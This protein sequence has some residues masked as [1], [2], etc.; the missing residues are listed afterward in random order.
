MRISAVATVLVLAASAALAGPPV[1]TAI[2]PADLFPIVPR[3]NPSAQSHYIQPQTMANYFSGIAT[4][5]T[6]FPLGSPLYPQYATAATTTADTTSGSPDI[7]VASTTGIVLGDVI[8]VTSPSFIAS[9]K[10][11]VTN[12]VGKTVT[13][14]ENAS[15]SHTGASV[16]F[17]VNRFVGPGSTALTNT[18]GAE[19]GY[20]GAASV[21]HST[22]VARYWGAADYPNHPLISA[23]GNQAALFATRASDN[24]FGFV[25]TEG[26][27]SVDDDSSVAHFTFDKYLQSNLVAYSSGSQHIQ[28]EQSI[29]NE[30]W[31]A[32]TLDPYTPNAAAHVVNLRID[33][34][35]GS[36]T[37]RPCSTPLQILNNGSDYAAGIIFD[38]TSVAADVNG[39][40]SALELP[41][42][43]TIDWF[44]GA[45]NGAWRMWSQATAGI[46]SVV[47][48]N[49]TFTVDAI[50]TASVPVVNS[51]P[52][53]FEL[54]AGS[55]TGAVW[56]SDSQ[57][58]A[59]LQ[60]AGAW[61]LILGANSASQMT[62]TPAG[63]V[64]IGAPTGGD[65]GADTLNVKGAYYADG[66]LGVTCSGSPTS[67][68][69]S[70]NGIVTHC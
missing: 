21:G 68:F 40:S 18:L 38:S 7:V 19:Y 58:F 12:I 37:P 16:T 25:I 56:A 67:S 20:F 8:S 69:A 6:F 39:H 11:Y 66:T 32:A 64:Q 45:G 60:T 4:T 27:L 65:K 22:W 34:G 55:V 1:Q 42:N 33:C 23:G 30:A 48:D 47:M 15:A 28:V 59:S 46:H 10:V 51:T 17:G 54:K 63:G 9:D 44:S 26:S 49:S 70:V 57:N 36:G 43:Y 41:K 35:I 13:L 29:Y 61:P 52:A 2:D 31:S 14:S 62:I 53:A 5:S 24:D 50:V 3:G